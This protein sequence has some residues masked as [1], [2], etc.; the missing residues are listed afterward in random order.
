MLREFSRQLHHPDRCGRLCDQRRLLAQRNH[1]PLTTILEEVY[2]TSPGLANGRI[3]NDPEL[4][5]PLNQAHP[6]WRGREG[7][8]SSP[9]AAV[10]RCHLEIGDRSAAGR[11]ASGPHGLM[12]YD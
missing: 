4:P 8:L 6:I 12:H 3:P 5:L 7:R 2:H 1:L 11:A 10:R 9:V